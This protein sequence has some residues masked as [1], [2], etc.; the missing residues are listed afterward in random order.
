MSGM[1]TGVLG[2]LGNGNVQDRLY[3]YLGSQRIHPTLIFSGPRSDSKLA[4][5]KNAAKMLFCRSTGPNR[6]FCASCSACDRIERDI[7][8][9]V[10]LWSEPDE[11]VIKI[12][13][14]REI[15]TR[16]AL[17]PVE[18]SCRVCIIDDCHRM[19]AAAANA[20]LK[21]L[22]E[23]G[24]SHYFW[25][26]TSQVGSLL[27]T[28]RSRCLE[29]SFQPEMRR[30]VPDRSAE[31]DGLYQ[32]FLRSGDPYRVTHKL[33]EKGDVLAFVHFLQGRVR[34]EAVAD[35]S[36]Y[37]IGEFD[38]LLELEHRLRSNASY[39]LLLESHL[40]AIR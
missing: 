14:I 40:A 8:P 11:E 18:G 15:C 25:L 35:S 24:Q 19:N 36:W 29:F 5:V 3:R 22:E 37:Q 13:F 17:T 7:F 31:F 32:D 30:V 16:M 38:R 34:Q 20:F 28:L 12:E 33:K 2:V 23:P 26:L 21:T 39:G 1:D 4:I 27:P 6:A 10:W 9:D